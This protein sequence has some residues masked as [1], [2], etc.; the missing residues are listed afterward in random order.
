[1]DRS[2][3]PPFG[4]DWVKATVMGP[5]TVGAVALPWRTGPGCGFTSNVAKPGDVGRRPKKNCGMMMAGL[6]DHTCEKERLPSSSGVQHSIVE[7]A[8]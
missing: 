3:Q 7:V 1:M 8:P 6:E 2:K 5:R 4:T